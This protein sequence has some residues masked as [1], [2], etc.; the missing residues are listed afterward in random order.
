MNLGLVTK[1]KCVRSAE[2]LSDSSFITTAAFEVDGC[3]ADS[4][5][6]EPK[7]FKES[8]EIWKFSIF[9]IK[10]FLA[11]KIQTYIWPDNVTADG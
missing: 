11:G 7:V 8:W 4:F 6:T 3:A 10:F 2:S 5:W 9:L 1:T